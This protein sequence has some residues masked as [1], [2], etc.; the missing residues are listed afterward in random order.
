MYPFD[1]I[2]ETYRIGVMAGAIIFT[3][4]L[5]NLAT[6]ASALASSSLTR[7]LDFRYARSRTKVIT[8]N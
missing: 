1:N 7:M 5:K 8:R 4:I 6:Y 3:I 2:P